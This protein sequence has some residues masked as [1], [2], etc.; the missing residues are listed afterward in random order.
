MLMDKQEVAKIFE[1]I[2]VLLEL[3]GDNPFKSRAYRNAARSIL[4]IPQDLTKM[5]KDGTL[6]ELEGIGDDL[7]EKITLLVTTGHLPYYEKLKKSIPQGLLEMMHVHGLGAKRIKTLYE[8]LG[9]KSISALK[10]ACVN[11]AISQVAGFGTKSVQNILEAI[12]HLETYRQRHLWWDAMAVAAPILEALRK[13]KGVERAEIAGSL[14]RKL[15][16]IGDLDFLVASE[17]PGAIMRW[18]TSQPGV[19]QIFA[20]G[21]TKASVLLKEGIQ[22]DLRIVPEK[23]FGF[24]LFYFTG[25][26]E[27]DIKMRQMAKTKGWMLS[28]WGLTSENSKH[29]APFDKWKK[30]VTETD[31]Y[32]AFGMDYIPPEL[33]E[34]TE[35]YE[36]AKKGKLPKLVEEKDIRGTF[37]NHTIASDGKSS[38]E[39]MVAAAQELG[40]EYLG[41]AD[42]SKASFQANGLDE[43]RLMKQLKQI[44]KLN[45][46]KKFRTYVFSGI[47]CDILPNGAL[48]CSDEMLQQLDYAVISVHNA[49]SQDE[50]TMTKRIIRAIEHPYTTMV[51]HVTGR[52][53]L[54]R[55]P[56]AVNMPKVIDACIAN[57]K[58]MELNANPQRLDMDWRLWH[59]ASER[60]L[61]CCI[62]TDAHHTEHLQFY[63]AG[64]NIARKGWLESK[65][66][67]NTYPLKEVKKR[68]KR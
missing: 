64:V 68:L 33:R 2:A 57:N 59:A 4:N 54:R 51:G 53:L 48:D 58:I 29:P 46:S 23:Q 66:I 34:D 44:K 49:L 43:E 31:I 6:T 39:E 12:A 62:N 10:E 13:V 14:R 26:K 42:H 40:W 16:T 15:E 50:K 67:L 20:Q 7:A 37:H 65:Q 11:G 30:A 61:M 22:A 24:A 19:D 18:F 41:I 60:G 25:S 28:E 52:L 47:E 1:E 45:A 56:Y 35:E 38:L 63:R 9:I 5:V 21:D 55:E 32:K 3:K 36:A 8:K 27:H 17:C